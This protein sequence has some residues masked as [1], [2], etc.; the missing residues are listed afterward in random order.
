MINTQ[1]VF[2]IQLLFF[3]LLSIFTVAGLRLFFLQVLFHDFYQQKAEQQYLVELTIA[4]PRAHIYDRY[5]KALTV[6]KHAVSAFITP[7]NLQDAK[8]LR[9]FLRKYFP[10]ASERLAC[11]HDKTFLFVKRRLSSQEIALIKNKNIGDIQFLEEPCRWYPAKSCVQLIGLC[12]I[13]NHGIAGL[14]YI[15]EKMLAGKSSSYTL[16]KDARSGHYFFSSH[17]IQSGTQGNDLYLTIDSQLQEL[18]MHVLKEYVEELSA[19]E[20]SALILDAVNG[21]ILV[22]ATYPC[23]DPESLSQEEIGTLKPACAT[24]A[25]E[26]GS[27]IKIFPALAALEEK[28][29]TPEEKIDC[30]NK[31]VIVLNGVKFS[32]WKAHGLLPYEDVIALSN[33]VGTAKVTERLGP[34]LYDYLENLGFGKKTNIG[35]MGENPG[36]I[37]PPSKWTKHSLYS[38]SFGYEM[39]A[40]LVQ[41][42][43]AFTLFA[44]EGHIVE[45]RIILDEKPPKLS[46]RPVCSKETMH[47]LRNMM[48]KTITDGTAHRA[49]SL[50]PYGYTVLGKTGT[51]NLLDENGLYN[52]DRNIF[53]FSSI[54]ERNN[55]PEH[56]K[57]MPYKRIITVFVREPEMK[58]VY[59]SRIAV[60]LYVKVAEQMILREQ[61]L[62]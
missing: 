15:Y 52:K 29:V 45:P 28:V 13:D 21:D 49:K 4:P 42:A 59:A 26:L 57:T 32:T 31:Q 56:E 43:R 30:E 51:A 3:G 16:E 7:K 58:G 22:M 33:N 39:N 53:T 54:I 27:V 25:Y 36:Y 61:T 9:T 24:D 35:L 47:A 55:E 44:N 1:S 19:K 11:Q 40:T 48:Q 17:E 46:E 12:D 2:R 23:P 14:E 38:L 8:K 34:S 37:N 60:P 62:K 6:N 20:A 10:Q 41:L 50:M 5:G 18:V